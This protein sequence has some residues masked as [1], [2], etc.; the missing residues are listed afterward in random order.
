VRA[1]QF[2]QV[3]SFSYFAVFVFSRVVPLF[4][5]V[6]SGVISRDIWLSIAPMMTGA[7]YE[8]W[9]TPLFPCHS[10][11]SL[12]NLPIDLPQ[13]PESN[14]HCESTTPLL[15]RR[16]GCARKPCLVHSFPRRKLIRRRLIWMLLRTPA[17]KLRH[18]LQP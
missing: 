10:V 1:T 18:L 13:N 9:A 16:C 3:F 17:C 5:Q 4:G 12:P 2:L 7:K 14:K 15:P 8:A 11:N 6:C